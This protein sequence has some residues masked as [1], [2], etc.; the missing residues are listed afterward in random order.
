MGS[1]VFLLVL[2]V[3]GTSLYLRIGEG[4][5]SV[6]NCFYMTVITLSTVGFAE[7]LPGMDDVPAAR[8]LTLVL[9]VLG[10]GTLLYFLSSL[11]AFIV[12]GDLRGILRKRRMQQKIDKHE[13]HIVVCGVGNTGEHIVRE[14]LAMKRP[15]V[16]IDND[17]Q[18]IMDLQQ[19][20]ETEFLYVLGDAT[21]DKSLQQAGIER[22]QGVIAA[23]SMDK[24]NLFVTISARALNS[25]ARIVAKAIEHA[26]ERKLRRAGA[27][28][29][30]SP[31][32][33]GGHRLVNEMIRP[34]AVEF[35]DRMLRDTDETLRIEEA[36]IPKG[37]AIVGCTLAE[38]SIRE[39]GALVLAVRRSTGDYVY[40]PGGSLTLNE[41]DA[42]IVIA[43][44]QDITRLNDG[45]TDGSLI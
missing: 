22:A 13:N 40:N 20:F 45:L 9:I 37:S 7:T 21:A 29:V 39:T 2:V 35:L 3:I 34:A 10:S 36:D 14:L 25:R 24:D 23:L 33:I 42:L 31:N 30:V 43:H 12:E 18:R 8:L 26:N 41:G 19:L 32:E 15:F 6:F 44:P 4:Q 16:V 11:T 27:N 38:V 28:S 17:E 5:W 1:A